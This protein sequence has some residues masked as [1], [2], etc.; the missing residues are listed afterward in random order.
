M[1]SVGIGTDDESVLEFLLTLPNLELNAVNGSNEVN[2]I[3][4]IQLRS[5]IHLY[6][7][8]CINVTFIVLQPE[9][10]KQHRIEK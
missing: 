5:I 7:S 2:P 3:L 1:Y 6:T 4:F 8:S 9:M 10:V